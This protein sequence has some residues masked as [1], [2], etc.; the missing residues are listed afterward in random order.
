MSSLLYTHSTAQGWKDLHGWRSCS[1]R[2]RWYLLK[3]SAAGDGHPAT[4]DLA[5]QAADGRAPDRTADEHGLSSR[6]LQVTDAVGAAADK[7]SAETRRSSS[8]RFML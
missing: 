7:R 1:P 2:R 6:G 8:I 5:Q 4:F 3:H